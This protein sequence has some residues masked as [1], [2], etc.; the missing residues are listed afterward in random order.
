MTVLSSNNSD[1]KPESGGKCHPN[2]FPCQLGEWEDLG[3]STSGLLLLIP[4]WEIHELFDP[5]EKF[6]T[7]RH[8]SDFK[9][10]RR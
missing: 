4:M 5:Q 10:R 2:S 1:G 8:G 3:F 6:D 9:I 7:Q